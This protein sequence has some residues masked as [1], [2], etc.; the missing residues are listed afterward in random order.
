MTINI[1]VPEA[2]SQFAELL[3]RVKQGE[4]VLILEAWRSHGWFL[5]SILVYPALPDK[6]QAESSLRPTSM[7]PCQMIFSKTS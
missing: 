6:M 4:D 1:S 5:Q 3:N 2:T 7:H